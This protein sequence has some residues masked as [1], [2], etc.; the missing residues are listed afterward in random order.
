MNTNDLESLVMRC[1]KLKA[2][3]ELCIEDIEPSLCITYPDSSAPSLSSHS[4]R[5]DEC[6]TVEMLP[7]IRDVIANRIDQLEYQIRQL[8]NG[9]ST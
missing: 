1:N 8:V 3:R 5:V 7:A 6:D 9:Q 4:H 2:F